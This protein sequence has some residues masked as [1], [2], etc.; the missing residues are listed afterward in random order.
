VIYG[1]GVASTVWGVFGTKTGVAGLAAADFAVGAFAFGMVLRW[2][3]S[4]RAALATGLFMVYLAFLGDILNSDFYKQLDNDLG[5][6]LLNILTASVTAVVA[7]YFAS[8]TTEQ[9]V[10][11]REAGK[12]SRT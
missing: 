10:A 7:F 4:M 8:K 11:I 1:L 9:V 12:A 6:Q 5:K 2:S 3:L